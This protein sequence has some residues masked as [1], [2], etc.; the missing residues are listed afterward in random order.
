[1]QAKGTISRRRMLATLG[2]GTTAFM[3]GDFAG[4][5]AAR[6]EG[7]DPAKGPFLLLC[8][9]SGGWDT[10]LCLDPRAKDSKGIQRGYDRVTDKGVQ[11]VLQKSG[12]GI[13]KPAGSKIE[14][15][16]AI[17][18]L[19]GLYEDL[20]VVR[21]LDMQSL[22]H[23][24][25][26]RYFL[27]GK[28]PRGLAA[29]GSAM[30][31][32]FVNER[33]EATPIP[34]LVMG[35]ETYN[36][37]LDPAA[38]GLA[39]RGVE[40]LA[41][42][43]KPL[44]SDLA[45]DPAVAGKVRDYVEAERCADRRLDGSGLVT[46]Y[47]TS[48]EQA[49]LLGSGQL[50][51]HFDFRAN[52]SPE[53]LK[54]YDALGIDPKRPAPDLVGPKGQAAIAAQAITRGVSHAV[55]LSLARGLD[56]H[57]DWDADHATPLREGFDALAGLIRYLKSVELEGG[58]SY[59]DHTVVVAFSEFARTPMLNPRGG[60]DHHLASSCLV[61]GKGIRGNTVVGR[62]TDTYGVAPFEGHKIRPADVHATVFDALGLSYEHVGNQ[63]PKIIDAMKK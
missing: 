12:S 33:A 35:V 11:A 60:R 36:D 46:T 42:L 56:T 37:G 47:K 50:W 38:N 20:C 13:V 45:L 49:A 40:D 23:E 22:T 10:L 43:L 18:D 9:F 2:L 30:P 3:L 52:P 53:I 32:V 51:S 61:A 17:G 59:W 44:D 31:T 19:A 39:I 6:A 57:D 25:G 26:R 1:M 4:A 54:L 55:S 62:T 34:N 14:F 21:G 58:E 29:S 41:G 24:V 7:G 8:Y 28:F 63:N 48:R 15:G 27:T 5:G 16:P